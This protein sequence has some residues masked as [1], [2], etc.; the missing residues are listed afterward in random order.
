MTLVT[1]AGVA[2]AVVGIVSSQDILPVIAV[3]VSALSSLL[4]IFRIKISVGKA[5]KLANLITKVD[6][7]AEGGKPESL[8]EAVDA[9]KKKA[10]PAGASQASV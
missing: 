10:K 3:V 1:L 9:L 2:V 4:R 7:V 8:Q 6:K 5:E